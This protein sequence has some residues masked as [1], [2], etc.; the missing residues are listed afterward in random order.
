MENYQSKITTWLLECFG[1]EIASDKTERSFRFTE[2]S[3]E[4]VQSLGITKEQVLK[5]VEYV[6]NRT[7]GEPHQEVGGTMVTLA[8]LCY[9]AKLDMDKA[10]DDEY[11]RILLNVEKIRTKHFNKPK[12][13]LSPIPGN[14]PTTFEFEKLEKGCVFVSTGEMTVTVPNDTKVNGYVNIDKIK[15][16]IKERIAQHSYS[17]HHGYEEAVHLRINE[18]EALLEEINENHR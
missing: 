18:L 11:Q 4:L 5:L 9:A 1:E 15:N 13:V 2:E 17:H 16:L 8:A 6:F 12:D 3:L 14:Y 7:K 10:A